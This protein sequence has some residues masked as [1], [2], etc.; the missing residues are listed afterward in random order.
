MSV[1]C[2]CCVFCASALLVVLCCACT[3]HWLLFTHQ[4]NPPFRPLFILSLYDNLPNAH[5]VLI[6]CSSI[7]KVIWLF[8]FYTFSPLAVFFVLFG[9]IVDCVE[10]INDHS[11]WVGIM[12]SMPCFS[13]VSSLGF[14]RVL[15]TL[16]NIFCV[17]FQKKMCI[18]VSLWGFLIVFWHKLLK[19]KILLFHSRKLQ[20]TIH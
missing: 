8:G 3:R 5:H 16:I 14:V 15:M 10:T 19:N 2:F 4:W 6:P 13:F 1:V 9:L 17:T 12:Q 20:A 11:L 18:H 7:P